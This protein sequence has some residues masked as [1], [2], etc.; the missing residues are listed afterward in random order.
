M[1]AKDIRKVACVATGVIGSSWATG[2]A[3]KGYPVALYDVDEDKLASARQFVKKNLDYLCEKDIITQAQVDAAWEKLVFTTSM[4]EAVSDVQF[5]QESGPENYDIKRSILKRMEDCTAP[6][7]IIAS[8]TSGLKM[9]EIARDAIHPERCIVGHPYNP[10]HLIPLVDVC[11]GEKT[12]DETA[13]CTYDFY[14]LLGKE[15]ILLKKEVLGFIANRLQLALWREATEIVNRGICGVED[16]DKAVTYGPGLRWALV[17]PALAN[18]LNSGGAGLISLT[19]HLEPSW[20]LW[21]DDLADWHRFPYPNWAEV[22]QEAVDREKA[23]RDPALGNTD[24]EII[25][26]RDSATLELLK[27]HKKL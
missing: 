11:K 27:I 19:H 9:T 23:G 20:N 21:M 24:E 10:P 6:D 25:R 1:E 2:F 17:G 14:R 8:S 26:W 18:Q 15:P 7:T 22:Q 13:Q 4:E 5:I 3:M 12:S 16:I